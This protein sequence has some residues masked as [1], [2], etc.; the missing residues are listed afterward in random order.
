M[1]GLPVRGPL[2]LRTLDDFHVWP[3]KH[4][5]W[6]FEL[7]EDEDHDLWARTDDLRAFFD[8][9]PNDK[10]LKARH[11]RHMLYDKSTRTHYL[12]WRLARMELLKS[13]GHPQHQD[14][15]KFLDW[16]ERNVLDVVARKRA[17]RKLDEDNGLHAE[18]ANA[19]SGAVPRAQAH[20]RLDETT[21]PL[22]PEERWV[23]EQAED[24]PRKVYHPQA[25]PIRVGWDYWPREARRWVGE[26][27]HRYWRGERGLLAT[28]FLGLIVLWIP[29]GYVDIAIPA[30]LDWTVHYRRV[31]W[32]AALLV[33]LTVVTSGIYAFMLT[34]SLLRARRQSKHTVFAWCFYLF[35][36]P[37]G[38][39]NIWDGYNEE[40]VDYW[41]ASVRGQYQ[42]MTVYAD[43]H[44]GRIRATGPMRYG[45]AEALEK[46][47]TEHP[48][49]TLI[50][51]ESPGGRVVEGFRMAKLIADRKMDTAV[52]GQCASA[53]T[54]LF[55]T[56]QDRY[57]GP[58]AMLGFHRSGRRNVF[59]DAGWSATDHKI[60]EHYEKFGTSEEFISKA[61]KEPIYRVWWAPH[62]EMYGAGYANKA[63]MERKTGY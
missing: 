27:L 2:V 8:R 12:A 33:P 54:F 63:W 15:L 29:W 5:H 21:L 59:S 22:T 50:E 52:L 6:Q 45:S 43:P 1:K 60:A 34:R 46:V 7:A 44:L 41:W 26:T 32:A 42:P 51:L 58:E 36:L 39:T 47:L 10:E 23:L 17:V 61:L 11:H 56:G 57:L 16:L 62:A 9:F 40:L 49:Y 35:V 18:Y 14:I 4:R 28:F 25:R 37:F 3:V 30:S 20:P 19:V 38:L 31:M 53:C 24:G 48:Q 55:V 13:K